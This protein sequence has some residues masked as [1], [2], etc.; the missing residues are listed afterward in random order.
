M[1]KF[2]LTLKPIGNN[3]LFD[4]RNQIDE[5]VRKNFSLLYE[6]GVRLGME[7]PEDYYA[8]RRV[9]IDNTRLHASMGLKYADGHKYSEE[10]APKKEQLIKTIKD[11]QTLIDA[12]SAVVPAPFIIST[13]TL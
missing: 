7:I 1:T 10:R 11:I 4:L 12:A 9:Q 5:F 8:A 2:T 3:G 13:Q 6:G